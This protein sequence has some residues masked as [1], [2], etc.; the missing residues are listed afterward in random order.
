MVAPRLW[1][2][3][4]RRGIPIAFPAM[5]LRNSAVRSMLGRSRANGNL[6]WSVGDLPDVGRMDED[7]EYP[8]SEQLRVRETLY[9][10]MSQRHVVLV[11]NALDYSRFV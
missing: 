9:G 4:C 6:C 5:F 3:C 10:T 2:T 8:L 1:R 7:D 11:D